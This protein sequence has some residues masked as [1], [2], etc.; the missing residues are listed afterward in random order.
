M[1]VRIIKLYS[2]KLTQFKKPSIVEKL[3]GRI[4]QNFQENT[5]TVTLKS[6]H[7]NKYYKF[8]MTHKDKKLRIH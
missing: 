7:L 8:L 1:C 3:N 5:L 6:K 2:L 4:I